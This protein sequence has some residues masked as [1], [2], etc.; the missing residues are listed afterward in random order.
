MRSRPRRRRRRLQ[1][2]APRLRLPAVIMVRKSR[3]VRR[4]SCRGE[5]GERR[6][7][8]HAAALCRATRSRKTSS[9]VRAVMSELLAQRVERALGDQPAALDHADALGHAL[10]HFQDMRGHD[11]GDAGPHA[12]DQHV[13]RLPRGGGIEAGQ[14]LVQDQ[15]ARLV[16]QRARQRHLLAHAL[17]E[18]LAALMRVRRETET[19]DQRA[20]VRLR[21]RR[22][23][24]PQPGHELEIFERRQLVVNRRLVGHPGDQPLGRDRIGQGV[25]AEDRDRARVRLE[26]PRDDAERGRLARPVR[27]E[28]RIE[29]ARAH[30]QV[31]T[32]HG[33][34]VEMLAEPPDVEGG[35]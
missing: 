29:L 5:P 19:L 13:L 21:P 9:R 15:Q 28:Q 34:L 25:D 11:D 6:G 27:A 1:A 4:S 35:W 18:A 14:R 22:L 33:G 20:R 26:Q 30:G 8:A 12:L 17:G 23:D 7:P 31:E 2:A 10:G 3:Q 32:V 16:H 24:A